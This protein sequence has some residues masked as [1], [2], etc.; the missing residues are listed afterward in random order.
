MAGGEGRWAVNQKQVRAF[1]PE[2][3]QAEKASL[4]CRQKLGG[5][6]SF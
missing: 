2:G 5:A 6:R 4:P 3:L 1:S